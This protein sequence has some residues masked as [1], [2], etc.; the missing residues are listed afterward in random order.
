M[1]DVRRYLAK[2][3]RRGGM[4]S[5]R[6]LD[7]Q[8]AR[9][10]VDIRENRRAAKQAVLATGARTGARTVLVVDTAPEA[11]AVQDALLRRMSHAR[12]LALV[13]SLSRTVDALARDGVKKRHP[14]ADEREIQFHVAVLRLGAQLASRAYGPR[15]G[16]R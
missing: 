10:M 12:K 6:V 7:P 1:S 2:I 9:Q 11:Q 4:R 16:A 13:A 3:G 8:T 15:R 14:R 5:R